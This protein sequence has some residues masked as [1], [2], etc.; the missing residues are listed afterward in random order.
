MK[1]FVFILA[2]LTLITSLFAIP[3]Y[4]LITNKSPF[5]L[6]LVVET[7][8]S[9]MKGQQIT[10]YQ[11]NLTISPEKGA[12]DVGCKIKVKFSKDRRYL[13]FLLNDG[14][15]I[16]SVEINNRRI[17]VL[18]IWLINLFL[19]PTQPSS[20]PFKWGGETTLNL[21]Y[22]GNLRPLGFSD[23]Y[24]KEKEFI[25]RN[26]DLWY[27]RDFQGFFTV[28]VNGIIPVSL[29]PVLPG[30]FTTKI[31]ETNS[32]KSE[33]TSKNKKFIWGSERPVTGFAIIGGYF[34]RLSRSV[35]GIDYYMYSPVYH[36]EDMNKVI[37]NIILCHSFFKGQ[38]GDDRFKN[39][40]VVI[41]PHGYR[42]YNHG[43]GIITLSKTDFSIIAHE[44]AHN[45]WG[46]TVYAGILKGSGDGGQWIIEGFAE[47][48]SLFAVERL[49]GKDAF[50]REIELESFNPYKQRA[51][52][53]ITTF[54]NLMDEVDIKISH[55]MIYAKGSY[56]LIM[57]REFMG[58]EK[59]IKMIRDFINEFQYRGAS[60]LDF[61]MIAERTVGGSLSWFFD[62]WIRGT[63]RL[64]YAITDVSFWEKEGSY[65]TTARVLNKGE[66][67]MPIDVDI[68]AI[69]EKGGELKK[70]FA[71]D[72]STTVVFETKSKI[73]KIIIDP[74][75]KWADMERENNFVSIN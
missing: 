58:E 34:K 50:L 13:I 57:M 46:G 11:I 41:N 27:P 62:Q 31:I 18:R 7:I 6:K 5:I 73:K 23:G 42:S 17:K 56:V 72:E 25:L 61:Q 35:N 52:E 71:G 70:I 3:Y 59:F 19:L 44:I 74:F 75:M 68:K 9:L 14:L 29:T 47:F 30:K 1:R 20:P 69:T 26:E 8:N 16:N 55:Q 39:L 45:W 38:F 48:S 51:I 32:K 22:K 37:D 15:T 54:D 65:I 12:I 53:S 63:G 64:D 10:D 2:I 67:R 43:S 66:I 49:Q 28:T 36:S 24:I 21:A 4:L 33:Q 60:S 40:T